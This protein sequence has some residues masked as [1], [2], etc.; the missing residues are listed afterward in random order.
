MLFIIAGEL[1]KKGKIKMSSGNGSQGQHLPRR[2]AH[3]C[4]SL[5]NGVLNAL[6]NG[7]LTSRSA[8]PVALDVG[9]I[10]GCNE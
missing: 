2:I 4:Y 5:L 1:L 6:W 10:T 7:D 9:N 3:P 8:I